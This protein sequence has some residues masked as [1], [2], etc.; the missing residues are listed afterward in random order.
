MTDPNAKER[1]SG[2]VKFFD[3]VK[4]WGFIERADDDDVFVHWRAIVGHGHRKLE[5]GDLVEFDIGQG[6]KGDQALNVK[7]VRA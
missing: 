4:G 5:A 1:Q 6:K 3:D 2:V 7:V